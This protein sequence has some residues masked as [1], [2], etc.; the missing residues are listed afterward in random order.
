[1]LLSDIA[2]HAHTAGTAILVP[3]L[4]GI[5]PVLLAV[6][7]L[8]AFIGFRKDDN[9]RQGEL[10]ESGMTPGA[11]STAVGNRRKRLTTCCFVVFIAGG[12][13]SVLA[14]LGWLDLL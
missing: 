1:M 10:I 13:V 14:A 7:G 11:A 2:Q 3:F 9:T 4:T 5:G 8:T 12:I 6:G